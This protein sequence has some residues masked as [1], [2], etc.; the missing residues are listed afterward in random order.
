[1][2]APD[3]AG[4]TP[5]RR[6]GL[7][8]PTAAFGC[9]LLAAASAGVLLVTGWRVYS[10]VAGWTAGAAGAAITAIALGLA[11]GSVQ[12]GMRAMTLK[13]PVATLA[14]VQ[15][16]FS[17]AGFI[18]PLLFEA[19]QFIGLHLWPTLGQFSA[20]QWALQLVAALTLFLLPAA[21]FAAQPPILGRLIF[22][23]SESIGM[24]LGFAFG[25][26]LFGTG[27]GG[28]LAGGLLLASLGLRGTFW[29]G[30][31]LAGVAAAGTV[32]LR[33][34]GMEGQGAIGRA[35]QEGTAVESAR[36]GDGAEPPAP[37]SVGAAGVLGAA[38][39]LFSFA[40]WGYLVTWQR[41]L[42]FILGATTPAQA[43]TT[44]AFAIAAA[45]G[46]VLMAGL[47]DRVAR[48]FLALTILVVAASL[49]AYASMFLVPSAGLLYLKT[50]PLMSRPLL[51][52]APMA[53]TGLALVLPTG[54]LLG[55]SL[56]LLALAARS[57]RR[58]MSGTVMYLALGVILAEVLL[59]LFIVP[60]FGLRRAQSLAAAVGLLSA[61]VFAGFAPARNPALRTTVAL[62]LLGLMVVVGGF[63]AAWDPRLVGAG[64]YRYGAGTL[65]RY[66]STDEYFK[67]RRSVDLLFYREGPEATVTVERT[68]T[69]GAAGSQPVEHLAVTVDGKVE[70]TTGSDLRAQVLQ[71]H[72]PLL[73]HGPADSVLLVDFLTGVTAGSILRH[74][75]KS[76]TIIEREP[77]LFESEAAFRDYNQNPLEDG[78]LV[79]IRDEGRARL[80]ADPQTYDV[81]ILAAMNPWLPH[82]AALTT[83]E[84]YAAVK[85]RLRPGGLLAQR[86]PLSAAPGPA[87]EAVL[88]TFMA[89]F[90]SVLL[91]Q[92]S[93]DDL[94]ILGSDETLSID[95][96]WLRNVISSS[97]GVMDDLRRVVVLGPN[98][99]VQAYRLDAAGLRKAF[100][101]APS[102]R[103]DSAAV[104]FAAVRDPSVH[105]NDA[106]LAAIE[107]ARGSPLAVLRNTGSGTKE[108]TDFLYSLAKA[109]LGI[110]GDP[111]RAREIATELA[112]LGQNAAA[113]WVTG[114][115]LLQG[116]DIDGALGEWR[117]VLDLEPDNLDALFSLGTFY[118]DERD[119]WRADPYLARAAKTSGKT[120]PV[121][122]HYGRN[123]FYLGRFKE[124][125]PELQE[126]VRLGT[127]EA[128]ALVPYLV[129]ISQLRL[130]KSDEAVTSLRAYLDWAYTQ[131][132][133]TRVEVD[134]HL[135]LAEALDAQGKRFEAHK[136]REKGN[137]LLRR[138]QAYAARSG[139]TGGSPAPA[140][141]SSL[142]AEPADRP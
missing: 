75:V 134:A 27:L 36:G 24:G 130:G 103:D 132:T 28:G 113:R 42:S 69:G 9:Y 84:G 8:G 116:K 108:R 30:M 137:E 64:L 121:R 17:L 125:I 136:E 131:Q 122:Y 54:L 52:G 48:P 4:M 35:L 20:G 76:L 50:L 45:L 19:G 91:F 92:V 43:S 59:P 110:A 53:L 109:F 66:G 46:A 34:F 98:E 81:V 72:I 138:I 51:W 13:R 22:A 73:V 1:M 114:E 106:I 11:I 63:P 123:L 127:P 70:A 16:A 71:G 18:A 95:I 124:A 6:G 118:L 25:L 68:L 78:R 100:G 129:G 14:V 87:I 101:E 3:P 60:S 104:E 111:D 44:A 139:G 96:G 85:R 57:R 29:M 107:A 86:V 26:T 2:T 141:S 80:L 74:P 37:T 140:G 56:P 49:S 126:A 117:A 79:R 12:S 65:E 10:L 33:Q 93:Q 15:A 88:R 23:G 90:R 102:V 120:A 89:S 67:M 62:A 142:P 58:L 21:L 38:M 94:L 47:A 112:A 61:I 99:I 41:T 7:R 82:S 40:A 105:H 32:L 5:Q 97:T 83:A 128:Y 77:A 31:A 133:L 39:M 119:F 55:A 135:K 115:C